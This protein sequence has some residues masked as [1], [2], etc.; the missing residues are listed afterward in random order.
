MDTID[1][2]I[3]DIDK[4]MNDWIIITQF[5]NLDQ[6]I[7]RKRLEKY[8]TSKA[9]TDEEMNKRDC[10]LADIFNTSK[11]NETKLDLYMRII[12][13][14]VSKWFLQEWKPQEVKVDNADDR[15]N[16]CWLKYEFCKCNMKYMD[17]RLN[18]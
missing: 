6:K 11:D 7:L 9:P 18:G 5:N 8:L 4:I 1:K 12:E 2:I 16:K 17:N 13:Y 14:L 3:K 10:D 15:C